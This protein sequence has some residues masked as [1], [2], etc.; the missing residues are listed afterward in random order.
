MLLAAI[1]PDDPTANNPSGLIKP[2]P[3]GLG[4][5]LEA[6]QAGTLYFRINDSA[7]QLSDNAGTATV[8][9]TLT[10]K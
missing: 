7:G 6:R 2:I 10:A 9:V 1:R 5:T 4:T 3:V 8:E